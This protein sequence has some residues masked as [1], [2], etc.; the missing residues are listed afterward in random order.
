MQ[1]EEQQTWTETPR[2]GQH[3]DKGGIKKE[4]EKEHF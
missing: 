3:V 1:Q 4:T 2:K